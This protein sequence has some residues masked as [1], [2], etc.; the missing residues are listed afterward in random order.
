MPFI[1]RKLPNR[2]LYSVKSKD[3]T[4]AKATTLEKAKAQVRLLYMMENR[5]AK[6]T[7][8]QK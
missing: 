1:I 8:R 3:R 7:R 2:R 6:G 4:F 5:N